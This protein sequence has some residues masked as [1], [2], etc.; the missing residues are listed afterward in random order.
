M[1]NPINS[2]KI[3]LISYHFPPS[4]GVG[5]I[6][7][8]KFAK[9]LPQ[10]G[11]HPYVLTIDEKYIASKDYTR[12]ESHLN[13]S[14]SKTSVWKTPLQVAVSL[15]RKM[16]NIFRE[17]IGLIIYESTGNTGGLI[18]CLISPSPSKGFSQVQ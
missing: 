8:A 18:L 6:R 7:P 10:F 13:I 17:L 16:S 15:K 4:A 12:I 5:S 14:I 1:I 2:R 9:Y 11:W 3:L